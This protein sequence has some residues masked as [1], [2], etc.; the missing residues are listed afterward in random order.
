MSIDTTIKSIRKIMRKDAG[1]DGDA[2]RISQMCWMIF[3]KVFDVK[4]EDWSL[5]DDYEPV[6]PIGL[7]WRDWAKDPEGIT[8]DALLDFINNTLFTGLKELSLNEL[9]P[10][11]QIVRGVFG[12]SYNYMKSGVLIRQV[13]NKLNE[14]NFGLLQERHLFNDIYET[15]LK[16][17]QSAGSAGEFYTPRPVTQ[18][19]VDMVNPLIGERILDP[20]CGTGGFLICAL[21]HLRKLSKGGSDYQILQTNLHGTEKKPLPHLLAMTNLI[22]HDIDFPYIKHD[23]SLSKNVREY[24]PSEKYDLIVTNPPFG[25]NEEEGVENSVPVA[26]RT[27]ETADLFLVLI[28]HI[29]KGRGRCGMVLPDGFLFGEGVKTRIKEE[30]LS[31]FNLHTIVRLPKGVFSPYTD[32]NTNLL[33]FE[34]GKPTKEVWYFEHPLPAEYKKYTKTKPIRHDEFKLEKD[35]WFNRKKTDCAWKVSIEEIIKRNYDL[36]IKNPTQA[37]EVANHS[38]EEI[39]KMIETGLDK[40]KAI[41]EQIKQVLAE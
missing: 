11:R 35:W 20:A 41:L 38:P 36:D 10:R 27:R 4:E 23:N 24:K 17:L 22:L 25:G 5:E 29:L 15:I 37:D 1:V 2:Q 21:E 26:F 14:I 33:F 9:N 40:S 12:D 16:E 7:R 30:L 18:F 8:G 31:K 6:V 13:I 3:L 19:I 39:I 28:M 34:K 32:I